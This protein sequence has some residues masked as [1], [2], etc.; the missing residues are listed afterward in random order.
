MNIVFN[1]PC[2]V[3]GVRQMCVEM[4]STSSE[5]DLYSEL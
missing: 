3:S 4:C 2:K 5:V 1:L